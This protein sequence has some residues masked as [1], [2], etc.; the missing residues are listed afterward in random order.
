MEL[1]EYLKKNAGCVEVCCRTRI[2]EHENTLTVVALASSTSFLRYLFGLRNRQTLLSLLQRLVFHS[3]FKLLF[4]NYST[5]EIGLSKSWT[6]D[7]PIAQ[8]MIFMD[9]CSWVNFWA[10]NAV[11]LE[12]FGACHVLGR[13]S[14]L[15]PWSGLFR[16][17]NIVPLLEFPYN[18]GR[19]IISETLVSFSNVTCTR[20]SC[21]GLWKVKRRWKSVEPPR[22]LGL[23]EVRSIILWELT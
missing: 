17:R 13:G 7:C 16:T 12:P 18:S 14:T 19:G 8:S 21:F 15:E 11:S 1:L 6:K 5:S 22:S 2:H 3:L 23:E 10:G 4:Q 9:V 20:W